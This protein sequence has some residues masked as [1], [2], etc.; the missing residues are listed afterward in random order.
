MTAF[1]V[2]LIITRSG[3][4][5]QQIQFGDGGVDGHKACHNRLYT[6]SHEFADR[7]HPWPACRST[8]TRVLAKDAIQVAGTPHEAM[9]LAYLRRLAKD[10]SVL[11]LDTADLCGSVQGQSRHRVRGQAC[12]GCPQ[13]TGPWWAFKTEAVA[14]LW[15][16]FCKPCPPVRSECMM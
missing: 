2:T 4:H 10:S 1:T 6:L 13:C 7:S 8:L 16:N 9:I 3:S 14:R 15:T 5:L 11:L 12:T